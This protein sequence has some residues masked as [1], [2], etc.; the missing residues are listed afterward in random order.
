M[1]YSFRIAVFKK[2]LKQLANKLR[3]CRPSKSYKI[4]EENLIRLSTSQIN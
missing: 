1:I 4:T 2:T 3:I